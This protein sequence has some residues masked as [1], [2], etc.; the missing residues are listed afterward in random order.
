MGVHHKEVC[1]M[2]NENVDFFYEGKIV[3]NTLK[4]SIYKMENN[5]TN[6]SY[7]IVNIGNGNVQYGILGDG[8][9]CGSPP[10]C[11]FLYP[12][13]FGTGLEILKI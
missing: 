4:N 2:S 13:I 3:P 9:W 11:G 8:V 5:N 7:P 1:V 12:K 6:S 10:N